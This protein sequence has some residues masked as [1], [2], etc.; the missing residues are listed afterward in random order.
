LV[1]GRQIFLRHN[2]FQAEQS[3][4]TCRRTKAQRQATKRHGQALTNASDG[5]SQ[6]GVAV[7]SCP[8]FV[9]GALGA[10]GCHGESV[11]S[12][13]IAANRNSRHALD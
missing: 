3:A 1:V 2:F 5:L 8:D 7:D 10:M 6:G 12:D 13:G 11:D 9:A 4:A